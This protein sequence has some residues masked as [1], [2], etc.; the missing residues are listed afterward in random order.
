M[1]QSLRTNTHTRATT[2]RK[3]SLPRSAQQPL[4]A[5][6][7]AQFSSGVSTSI[8]RDCHDDIM[9]ADRGPGFDTIGRDALRENGADWPATQ[10]NVSLGYQI[11]EPKSKN[12][13]LVPVKFCRD[14]ETPK[15]AK[16]DTR[17]RR[18]TIR[19][20]IVLVFKCLN[21]WE[22]RIGCLW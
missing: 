8:I 15:G 22:C 14:F 17:H 3:G 21:I 18:R 7:S 2:W 12:L 19:N 6:R 5:R 13:N 4:T 16:V 11:E 20:N 9:A 10:R 1:L